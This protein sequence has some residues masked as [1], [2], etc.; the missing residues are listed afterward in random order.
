MSEAISTAWM[1]SL[2]ESRR[3]DKDDL[4]GLK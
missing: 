4:A 3:P 1:T 2:L